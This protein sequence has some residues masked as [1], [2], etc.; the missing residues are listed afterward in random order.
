MHI[1]IMIDSLRSSNEWTRSDGSADF[2]STVS[3]LLR[4]EA[5]GKVKSRLGVGRIEITVPMNIE[6]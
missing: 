6:L 3:L 4:R 5:M 1:D 2:L